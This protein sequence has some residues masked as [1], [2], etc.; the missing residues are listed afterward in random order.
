[1]KSRQIHKILILSGIAGIIGIVVFM[2]ILQVD[3][4]RA[5]SFIEAYQNL[6]RDSRLLT[7]HY[8]SE[9]GKWK[10]K[11]Y[12]N[13][14]MISVTD[15]YL[16]E[17]QKIVKRAEMLHP[18]GKYSESLG[19]IIKSFNSEILSYKHFRIFLASGNQAEDEKSTQLLS[20]A[21]QYE[22]RSFIS[23]RAAST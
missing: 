23:F 11:E 2:V 17:F 18:P 15:H 20:E 5:Q 19:L 10:I 3:I 9:I 7:Q 4:A 22:T 6:I 21:L 13:Y 12:N 8:Q 14:T 16:P 1:M